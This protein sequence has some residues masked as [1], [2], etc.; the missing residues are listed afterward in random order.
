[1]EDTSKTMNFR[2]KKNRRKSLNPM[3]LI[4]DSESMSNIKTKTDKPDLSK[5]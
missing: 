5:T 4:F 2:E 3:I 1:M